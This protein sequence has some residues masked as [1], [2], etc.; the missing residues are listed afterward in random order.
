MTNG[1]LTDTAASGT[2]TGT[3]SVPADNPCMP[4]LVPETENTYRLFAYTPVKT[5]A[6][7]KDDA[8]PGALNFWFDLDFANTQAYEL[9]KAGSNLKVGATLSW[10]ES[11]GAVKSVEISFDEIVR[12]WAAADHSKNQGLYVQVT[13]IPY[14]GVSNITV[15]PYFEAENTGVKITMTPIS[16]EVVQFT[17]TAIFGA[18]PTDLITK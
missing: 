8:V 9:L 15:T 10:T 16:H 14:F 17:G 2:I 3:V 13:G 6:P 4:L 18:Y 12:N 11:N 5:T 7:K 1:Y